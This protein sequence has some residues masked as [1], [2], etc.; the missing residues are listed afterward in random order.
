MQA[1]VSR[2]HPESSADGR[3][4][5]VLRVAVG[6]TIGTES[7]AAHFQLQKNDIVFIREIPN[8][9]LQENVWVTGEV[10]FPGM[11]TLSS[12]MERLSSVVER[13]GGLE[14]TAYLPGANFVRKKENTGRMALDFDDALKTRKKGYSKYD[15]V[16]AA[17]DSIHIPRDPKSVKVTGAVGFPSSVLYEQGKGLDHYIDQ[18]GGLLPSA[19]KGKI[20]VVMAN[21]RIKRPG[22]FRSPEPDAGAVII[23][24]EKE[25]EKDRETLKDLGAIVTILS[26]AMTTIYLISQTS[27]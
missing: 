1:E 5:E 7:P 20:R 4:A 3:T 19:D 12:K 17:G 9:S 27:K 8:W 18:A 21:G 22:R 14:P 23:V 11:Y 24:P 2:V 16:L 6:D 13:A 25:P 26:G 10:K 15:L